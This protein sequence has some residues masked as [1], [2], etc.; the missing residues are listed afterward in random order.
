MRPPRESLLL[1]GMMTA[2]CLTA[3]LVFGIAT[4]GFLSFPEATPTATQ[5]PAATRLPSP[6]ITVSVTP[7][8]QKTLLLLGVTDATVPSTTLE[9]CWV[10]TFRSGVPEYYVVAIPPSATFNLPSLDGPRTLSQIHAEDVRLQLD[11]NFVRDAVQTRFPGLAIQAEIVLDRSDLAALVSE[12]GGLTI[13]NQQLNGPMLLAAYDTWPAA[14]DLDRLEYQGDILH[15]LFALLAERQWTAA[16]LVD[17]MARQPRFSG[18]PATVG[19]LQF[20]VQ[21]AP[22]VAGASLIWRPYGPELE[23]ASL[24]AAI[25]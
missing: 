17:F 21:D 19:D 9:A 13:N 15:H 11:H 6:D 22:P 4:G 16:H 2:A 7:G 20:F 5:A 10:I 25:P 18:D 1:L 12:L 3:G 8:L 23:A 24:P 14:S